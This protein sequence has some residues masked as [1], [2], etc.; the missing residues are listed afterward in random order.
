MVSGRGAAVSA[1]SSDCAVGGEALADGAQAVG[2]RLVH[3]LDGRMRRS[4][5][6]W[7]RAYRTGATVEPC[8]SPSGSPSSM[9]RPEPEI[10]ARRGRAAH[11]RARASRAR[12]R[13][14]ARPARRARG[15]RRGTVGRGVGHAVVRRRGLRGQ[16][17]RLRRPAQLVPRRRARSPPRHP[18]HLERGDDRGGPPVRAAAA[19][20]RDAR[21]LPRGRCRGRVVRSLPR[22]APASTSPAAPRCSRSRTPT[23]GS[24][25]SS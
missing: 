15:A 6:T 19:R 21:A 1:S 7:T 17:H 3:L 10:V 8:T 22:R 5:L 14:P 9:A 24:A 13:R 16:R 4:S 23:R 20:G 12:R 2:D 18:D 11:R 25:R